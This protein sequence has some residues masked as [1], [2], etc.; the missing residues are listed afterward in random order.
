MMTLALAAALLWNVQAPT[1]DL[2]FG[3]DVNFGRYHRGRYRASDSRQPLAALK[4]DL[5][6]AF[7]IVNLE[8]PIART[9]PVT[10]PPFGD[11][12]HFGARAERL[13]ALSSVGIKAVSLANNHAYDLG[14]AVLPD[15]AALVRVAHLEPFGGPGDGAPVCAELPVG[16]EGGAC[17]VALT[18]L[19]NPP[20][21][22]PEWLKIP[23]VSPATFEA[24]LLPAVADAAKKRAAV[25]VFLHW[26]EEYET[27][28]TEEQRQLAHALIDRGA[29]L[30][31]GHH[32]HVLQGL[33]RHKD[34]L[35]AYSL[36]NL[37][38]DFSSDR[39]RNGA[40]LRARFGANGSLQSV[41]LIPTQ[42]RQKPNRT[43]RLRGA[44][45]SAPLE[46][47]R[48]LSEA[49]GT[50]LTRVRDQLEWTSEPSALPGKDH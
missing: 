3:G 37:L 8:T 11:T 27:V 20:P 48:A 44:A 45:A 49:L 30:V 4:D 41:A 29:R 32:P 33:E 42:I 10:T 46:H 16:I 18:T 34:G 17:L 2:V 12:H 31:I 1:V 39:T 14:G 21:P 5:R 26:G 50:K 13:S 36:G 9:I 6:G 38:F 19:M 22:P 35:V 23:Q 24:Q 43:L 28:P 25:I 40:L 7:A 47:L 15:E